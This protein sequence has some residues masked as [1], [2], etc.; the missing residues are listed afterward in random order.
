MV[1]SKAAYSHSNVF[2]LYLYL[3]LHIEI[4]DD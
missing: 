2:S 3:D 1:P 4:N